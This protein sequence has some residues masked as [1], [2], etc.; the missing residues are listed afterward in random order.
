MDGIL[1]KKPAA[2]S[3]KNSP[4]RSSLIII[5][6]GKVGVEQKEHIGGGLVWYQFSWN[7]CN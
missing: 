7:K 2:A 1:T 4:F 3:L 6:S 5:N